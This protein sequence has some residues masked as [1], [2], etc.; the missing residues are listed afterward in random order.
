[1][2]FF[3]KNNPK[4]IN[5]E[6]YMIDKDI[7]QSESIIKK[8]FSD[9][10]DAFSKPSKICEIIDKIP[11]DQEIK[12]ILTT[13]GGSVVGC[14]KILKKL[15]K[16][17][18]GYKA[19][20]RN[21]SFSAGTIIALGAKEIIMNNDSYIGKI[22]PQ[23]QPSKKP[24]EI[25]FAT[26]PDKYIDS[27]NIYEVTEA[28]YVL[29]HMNELLNLIYNNEEDNFKCKK[30]KENIVNNLIFSQLPHYKSYDFT[31][32]KSM[33]K[34][35]VRPPTNEE[36]HYFNKSIEIKNYTKIN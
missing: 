18:S 33:L 24:H 6:I 28:K 15:L 10:N 7:D 5:N 30:Q 17:E 22:D 4:T 12:V 27:S 3:K 25:I 26:L 34:L 31:D 29:N 9:N 13:N 35:N 32:C 8:I 16:H 19:Y 20:I 11:Q 23:K 1:M 21:E 14:E 2:S 36:N